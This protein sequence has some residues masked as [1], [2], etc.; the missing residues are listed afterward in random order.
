MRYCIY[1]ALN[2]C[3]LSVFNTKSAIVNVLFGKSKFF[4]LIKCEVELSQPG[5]CNTLMTKMI[6][7]RHGIDSYN[8]DINSCKIFQTSSKHGSLL[9]KPKGRRLD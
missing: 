2:R 8:G 3:V 9:E 1:I 7:Q 5:D 4:F 6:F